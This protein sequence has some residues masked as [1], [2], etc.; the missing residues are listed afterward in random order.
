MHYGGK[1]EK[2]GQ[3]S[4]ALPESLSTEFRQALESVSI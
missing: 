2:I 4:R 3:I 1:E